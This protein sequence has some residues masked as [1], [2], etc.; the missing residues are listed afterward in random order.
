MAVAT[1]YRTSVSSSI[2]QT[3]IYDAI[4][5]SLISSGLIF[6]SE[7]TASGTKHCVFSKTAGTGTYATVYYR[8]YVTTALAITH[9]LFTAWNIATNTG[10][11]G[12]GDTHSTIFASGSDIAII[13]FN[14]GTE[15]SL[16]GVLQGSTFQLLGVLIPENSFDVWTLNRAPKACINQTS[17][18]SAWSLTAINIFSNTNLTA[19]PVGNS[20]LSAFCTEFNT[21]A[22]EKGVKLRSNTGQGCWLW[23]SSNFAAV[24]GNSIPRLSIFQEPGTG[25]NFMM[26][27][28]GNGALAIEVANA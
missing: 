9:Q 8:F 15:Y 27:G 10:S 25:K 24:P 14:G 26:L 23:T 4:K 5:S 19:D 17:T 16:V 28:T 6:V 21:Y 2:T 18:G 7:Y 22:P 12:S 11:N 13:A 3:L 20:L 1:I